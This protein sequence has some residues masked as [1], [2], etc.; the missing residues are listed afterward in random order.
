MSRSS[1][2]LDLCRDPTAVLI[3]LDIISRGGS[4]NILNQIN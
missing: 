1:I 3:H 4:I 2:S